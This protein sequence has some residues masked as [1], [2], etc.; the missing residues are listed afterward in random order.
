MDRPEKKETDKKKTKSQ[1]FV[2][3]VTIFLL[4]IIILLCLSYEAHITSLVRVYFSICALT[5]I[6]VFGVIYEIVSFKNYDIYV[7]VLNSN[8]TY[9]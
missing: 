8:N 6:H 9:R 5:S 2:L 1:K 7:L 4:S 3:H